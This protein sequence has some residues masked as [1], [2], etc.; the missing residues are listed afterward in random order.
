MAQMDPAELL[1]TASNHRLSLP[2]RLAASSQ[3]LLSMFR[4]SLP[5]RTLPRSALVAACRLSRG[6][7]AARTLAPLLIEQLTSRDSEDV[8][9]ALA[10][11]LVLDPALRPALDVEP[12]AQH[13]DPQVRRLAV[14]VW[15]LAPT[16]HPALAS[17]LALDSEQ[18]VRTAESPLPCTR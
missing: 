10:A 9:N 2:I 12:W 8:A 6:R 18:S 7:A 16:G 13:P 17:A 4:M 15:S 14:A 11:W 1:K 5:Q 3:H